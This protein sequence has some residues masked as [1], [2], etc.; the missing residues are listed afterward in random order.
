MSIKKKFLKN[1]PVCK[2][3]FE[4][5]KEAAQAA[6]SVR[7]VGDFNNWDPKEGVPMKAL[8]DGKFTATIDL[9]AGKEYQFRYLIDESRWENDWEADKYVPTEFGAENSVIVAAE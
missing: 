1:K 5:S 9:E 4:L 8:K 3:T 7:V 2:A 6:T